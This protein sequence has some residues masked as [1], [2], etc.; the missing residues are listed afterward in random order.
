MNEQFEYLTESVQI[1]IGFSFPVHS[2]FIKLHFVIVNGFCALYIT[3]RSIDDEFDAVVKLII[4][5]PVGAD[6]KYAACS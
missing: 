4:P 2:F 5:V 6:N 1:I 3:P